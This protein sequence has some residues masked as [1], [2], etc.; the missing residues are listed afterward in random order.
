MKKYDA[1]GIKLKR[2]LNPNA[3]YYVVTKNPD[4]GSANDFYQ[5]IKLDE[6]VVGAQW[7]KAVSPRK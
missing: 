4:L 5:H 2:R 7:D 3:Q 6:E 1:Y